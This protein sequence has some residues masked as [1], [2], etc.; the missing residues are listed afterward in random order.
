MRE[1]VGE[2]GGVGGAEM[3]VEMGKAFPVGRRGEGLG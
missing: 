2:R 3:G 1:K